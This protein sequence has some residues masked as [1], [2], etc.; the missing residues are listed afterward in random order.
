M[1]YTK[2]HEAAHAEFRKILAN[3]YRGYI[4]YKEFRKAIFKAVGNHRYSEAWIELAD[5]AMN[6]RSVLD[7]ENRVANNFAEIVYA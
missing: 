4:T 3:Y 1:K 6:S 7:Y 2:N 5:I